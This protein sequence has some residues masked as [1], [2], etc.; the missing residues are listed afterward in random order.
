M[1]SLKLSKEAIERMDGLIKTKDEST[2]LETA[3]AIVSDLESDGFE[4]IE[5]QAYLI[6]LINKL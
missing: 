4:K 2:F 3:K 5:V 6:H 1:S